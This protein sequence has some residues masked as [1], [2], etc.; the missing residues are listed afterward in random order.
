MKER[1]QVQ[2]NNLFCS[3]KE[4]WNFDK[5]L[6]LIL[7]VNVI[8]KALQPFPSIILSGLIIDSISKGENWTKFIF[9]IVLMF[10][11]QFVLVTA[12]IWLGKARDYLFTRF[13]NKL[14]NDI[15]QKCLNMDYEQFN[16]S[17]FQDSILLINQMVHGNNYFTNISTVF[18]T[19]SYIITLVGIIVIMSMLN[20]WLLLIALVVIV[21]QSLLH[22]IRQRYNRQFQIDTISEQRKLGYMSQLPKKIVAKKDIDMFQYGKYI[23]K[24]TE[25]FQHNMLYFIVKQ[26]K[27]DCVVD[28]TS[29]L[30]NVIF[31]VSVY[32]LIG[33]NAF[34]GKITVGEFTMGIT[35]LIN[36]LSASTIV[37]TNML[38]LSNSLSYINKYK[39][40]LNYKSKFDDE[41]GLCLEDINL[42]KIEIE[43]KNVSFRYPNST[44]YVLKNINL[45]MNSKEKLAI[46][47]YNGAGKTSF[48]LLLTRMYEPSE[49]EILLNG[50]NIQ[51]INY[52]EYLKIFSSVYQDF[53]L[54]PFSI[55]ENIQSCSEGMEE[56][57]EKVMELCKNYG[58]EERIKKMYKGLETPITKELYASGV[59]LSGGERQKI[60]ILRALYKNAPVLVLDEPTAALDPIAECEI[61]RKFAEISEGKL[62]VYISHRINSTRFCDKIA[63]FESGEITEYGTFDELMELKGLYYNFFET[64]AELYK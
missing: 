26:I 54:F 21:L 64:Q 36:F 7:F 3:F 9:Y 2:L 24:R 40:F 19:L 41:T 6:F 33:I 46:V 31:Q 14:D 45:K 20:N 37:A 8:I 56:E 28:T 10:G 47:G 48:T 22:I 23:M 17:Q 59:D 4:I 11:I 39:I 62:T 57:K 52:R 51:Q 55:V 27:K 12:S 53:F 63:V 32:I 34:L 38:N 60:A 42:E 18:D 13:T 43:F 30:F 5:F 49:G 44:S 15:N 61:Y 58:I 1:A 50:V 29:Y 35:S 16:D 25:M